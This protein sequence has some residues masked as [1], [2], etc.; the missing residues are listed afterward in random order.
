MQ[1][2]NHNHVVW[3]QKMA[4]PSCSP[5]SD[6]A[7]EVRNERDKPVARKVTSEG[8]RGGDGRWGE[9]EWGGGGAEGGR[10]KGEWKCWLIGWN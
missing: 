1:A 3:N 5:R 4:F 9:G 8:K 10:K 2:V 6:I 7:V